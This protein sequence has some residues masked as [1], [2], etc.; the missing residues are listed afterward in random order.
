MIEFALG[1]YLKTRT[2]VTNV[3]S[4][5]VYGH[6]APQSEAAPFIVY[7][8]TGGDRFYHTTGASRLTEAEIL[9]TCRAK[10]YALAHTLFEVLRDELDGYR[11]T[12]NGVTIRSAMLSTPSNASDAPTQGDDVGFPGVQGTLTVMYFTAVPT[13]GA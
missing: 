10:T 1:T 2:N 6:K 5:R 7:Q 8:Q 4:T 3:T 11:G 13:F 9:I 12:W